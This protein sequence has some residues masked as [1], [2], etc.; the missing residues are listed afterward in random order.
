MVHKALI[1]TFPLG[2]TINALHPIGIPL[3]SATTFS[4]NGFR[5]PLL[6][7]GVIF[8]GFTVQKFLT[9]TQVE[10]TMFPPCHTFAFK[11]AP[12]NWRSLTQATMSG[13][14]SVVVPAVT[15]GYHNVW[16]KAFLDL[17]TCSFIERMTEM[18]D[19]IC[20]TGIFEMQGCR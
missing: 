1:S 7:L 6:D 10:T 15:L 5:L 20:E 14:F 17:L 8:Q 4:Y 19:L 11:L 16:Y 2:C 3:F 12:P 9:L 13:M 18:L